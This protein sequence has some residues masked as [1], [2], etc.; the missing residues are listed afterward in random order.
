MTLKEGFLV[1]WWSFIGLMLG[2]FQRVQAAAPTIVSEKVIF[3]QLQ[4]PEFT[5]EVITILITFDQSIHLLVNNNTESVPLSTL[6]QVINMGNQ[7][8]PELILKGAGIAEMNCLGDDST[9]GPVDYHSSMEGVDMEIP[10][11]MMLS[12]PT[13]EPAASLVGLFG[14]YSIAVGEV[15]DRQVALSMIVKGID[16]ESGNVA[17]EQPGFSKFT[18]FNDLRCRIHFPDSLTPKTIVSASD[19]T[20]FVGTTSLLVETKPQLTQATVQRMLD[21]MNSYETVMRN[22]T[23]LEQLESLDMLSG[24]FSVLEGWSV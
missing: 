18:V 2:G 5:A 3:N 21:Y 15:S 17:F 24:S 6:N 13:S 11:Q 7:K 8:M 9:I 10:T 20:P 23:S 19:G 1:V 4:L 22:G 16:G 14:G 12:P